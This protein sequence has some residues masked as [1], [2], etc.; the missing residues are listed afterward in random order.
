M[1]AV[2]CCLPQQKSLSY[3]LIAIACAAAQALCLA[4]LLP[5]TLQ[6]PVGQSSRASRTAIS[7]GCSSSH[8]EAAHS[9]AMAG[10]LWEAINQA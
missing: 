10:C 3:A 9:P 8:G 6:A 7:R 2:A 1:A 5:R 4:A